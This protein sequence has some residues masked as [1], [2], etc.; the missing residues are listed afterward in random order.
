MLDSTEV[1]PGTTRDF[2][3]VA[4]TPGARYYWAGRVDARVPVSDADGQLVGA[5]VVDP[6]TEAGSKPVSDRV[7][8]LTRWTPSGTPENRGFQLNALNG[9]S[10]PN[11]ERLSYTTG[12]SVYWHV[13]NGSDA[14]HEMHLHGFYF[15]IDAIGFV[16]DAAG[17]SRSGVGGMRVTTAL[18]P[19]MWVSIA[20][21]PDRPGNW[22]YHCHLLTH[23][24]GAQRLDRMPEAIAANAAH[25]HAASTNVN[26]ALDDMGGLVLGL[27]VRPSGAA[28]AAQTGSHSSSAPRR[29][30]DVFA[31]KRPRTFGEAPGFGFVAQEGSEPPAVDSIRIPGT[32]LIL[33]RGEPVRIAVH[34]RLTTPI[35]VHWHGIE[36]DSYFDGVGGFSGAGTRIAPMIAPSDS[37]VVRFTP[38]RAG[39]FMYHVHG[40]S[41]EELAA[42][43]YAPLIVLERGATFDPRTDRVFMLSDGGPGEGRP[44]FVNGT[45]TPDSMQML[46]GTT[47]RLRFMI[48]SANETFMSTMTGPGGP[49]SW[50][51]LATDGYEASSSAQ[52]TARPARYIAGPGKTSDFA[53][54][55][56]TPGDYA[57]EVV[58]YD[59]GVT[60]GPTTRVPIRVRAPTS[61]SPGSP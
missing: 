41:G 50:R 24:S 59:F 14:T 19:G 45:S 17:A 36:L 8:V 43:L 6:P 51:P 23:M 60:T 18:G 16:M 34:N 2:R 9:R 13:I 38:P 46:V 31:N 39:T 20:W 52:S 58:R 33:T 29:S 3:F 11:T 47:Y 26:H 21:S 55:P 10:W 4:K 42:G 12:D 32:P 53:F 37:F 28:T 35:S 15:R 44:F 49:V 40:E 56:T 54:T 22:L 57:L 48:I 30:I 1:V 5:L 7:M 27:D 61:P 25:H